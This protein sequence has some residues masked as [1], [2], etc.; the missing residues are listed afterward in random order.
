MT[1][2]QYVLITPARNEAKYIG[3]L[4]ESVLAQTRPPLRWIIVDDGSTDGTGAVTAKYA[5][6][7]DFIMP[8]RAAGSSGRSFGSKVRAFQFA[9]DHL[10]G[11]RFEFIGNLDADVTLQPDYYG[12]ILEQF[13]SDPRLGIA[14]GVIFERTSVGSW[15]DVSSPD[16]VAG[17]IQF[18]RR[19]CFDEIGGL[20]PVSV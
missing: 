1:A 10:R 17:A 4:I 5:Q 8:L 6:L 19:Q 12:R 16:L 14:G 20:K 13:E 15:R 11:V 18:F 3:G 7:H 9:Y 2:A